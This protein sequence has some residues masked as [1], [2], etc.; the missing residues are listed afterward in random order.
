MEKKYITYHEIFNDI[1]EKLDIKN[2]KT[3]DENKKKLNKKIIIL[4]RRKLNSAKSDYSRNIS[5]SSIWNKIHKRK[6]NK[7]HRFRNSSSE[8]KASQKQLEKALDNIGTALY[9]KE[10]SG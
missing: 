7:L 4:R 8:F 10:E 3:K 9:K 2:N 6:V 5:I 1:Q